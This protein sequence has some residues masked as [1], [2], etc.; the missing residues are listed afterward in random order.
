M[1]IAQITDMHV[2]PDG[3]LMGQVVPTN[4]MLEAAIARINAFSPRVD[5]IL[6]TGDLTEG[7]T[8]EAYAA[9]QR[10]LGAAEPPV[11]LIPG[12]HDKPDALRAAFPTHD[13]LGSE[14]DVRYVVDDWPLRLIGLDTRIPKHPGG[15]VTPERLAWLEAQL[16]ARPDAPALLFLHHPPF[17]TG[18][19]WMDAIGLKGADALEE[20]V[21][22]HSNIVGVVCG[23]IHRSILRAWGGTVAY[24][25][26]STAHQMHLDLDG[27]SFLHSTKEP[28]AFA[29]HSWR[30]DTGLVTHTVYIDDFGKYDPPDHHDQEMMSGVRAFFDKARG[31]MGV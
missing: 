6:A 18:I 2:M 27:D 10:I 29:L 8:P 22:A 28:P 25:A 13:Y 21:R 4:A 16:D 7:G 1:L 20:I 9:L 19:W 23:H 15:E 11:F 14:G 31:E 24:V 5:A 26:P 17:R 3:Q 12:N 30:P